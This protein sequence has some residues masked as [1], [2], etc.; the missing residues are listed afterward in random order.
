VD[1]TAGL[2]VLT[3]ILMLFMLMWNTSAMRWNAAR[4]QME[5][6]ESAFFASEALMA[7]PGMPPSWEMLAH[8]D[9]NV[10][11]LGVVSG[12]NELNRVKL[13]KL[14]AE[15]ATAY[16]TIKARLGLQRYQFGMN[17]T[18]LGE[19]TAYYTFGRFSGG[20]LNNSIAF[21]RLAILDG[22]PVLVHMEVW[23]G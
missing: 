6:E 20:A 3:T 9:G 21:D 17:I 8:I 19:Q 22:N 11:A 4:T 15:N 18:D 7:T 10:S 5:R 23:G 12:R 13:D 16:T 14:V 2:V 1:F